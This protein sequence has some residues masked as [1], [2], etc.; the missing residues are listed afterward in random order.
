MRVRFLRLPCPDCSRSAWDPPANCN[1]E[2]QN[3]LLISLN[4]TSEHKVETERVCPIASGPNALSDF[5]DIGF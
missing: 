1:A 3:G 5:G 4:P 2:V